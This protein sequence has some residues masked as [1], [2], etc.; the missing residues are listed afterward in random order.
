MENDLLVIFPANSYWKLI[1]T[2]YSTIHNPSAFCYVVNN[3][4]R[5]L[6][7]NWSKSYLSRNIQQKESCAAWRARTVQ[8]NP[9]ESIAN[10]G[11][12]QAL[13]T[14]HSIP[15]SLKHQELEVHVYGDGI[16]QLYCSSN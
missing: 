16:V 7:Y 5:R 14:E 3:L 10:S 9:F 4:E 15:R 8:V 1:H 12:I 6:D 11:D 13:G 2:E